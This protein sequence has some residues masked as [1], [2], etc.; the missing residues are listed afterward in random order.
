MGSPKLGY[1]RNCRTDIG[2][3]GCQ[4]TE[5]HIIDGAFHGTA[6]GMTENDNGFGTGQL[7]SEFETSYD[8]RVDEITG[9]SSD[10]DVANPLVEDQLGRH[11]AVD[12][13]DHRS[14]WRLS[15]RRRP[16]L[17]HEIAVNAP[18]RDKARI[19]VL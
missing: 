17:G 3:G 6:I 5:F 13:S 19:T 8:I 18:A 15:R 10:K 1:L 9:D 11:T 7:G 12:T 2:E 14:E 16:N 4:Y